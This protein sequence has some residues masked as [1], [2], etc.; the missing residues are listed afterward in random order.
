M[1]I[2]NLKKINVIMEYANC[3]VRVMGN[4]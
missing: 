3:L 1:L 4:A 2:Q